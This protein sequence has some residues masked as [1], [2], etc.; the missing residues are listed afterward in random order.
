MELNEFVQEYG[1]LA[2]EFGDQ[3]FGSGRGK[4][5]YRYT[6][7]LSHSWWRGIVDRMI[8]EYNPKFNIAE[9][10]RSERNASTDVE[11]TLK[12]NRELDKALTK[13]SEDGFYQAMKSFGAKS[14]TEAFLKTLKQKGA[15]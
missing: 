6:S 9:A 1:R 8:L 15:V 7:D 3:Q 5:L 12:N 14:P 2:Q 4:L 10:A 13:C 11:R